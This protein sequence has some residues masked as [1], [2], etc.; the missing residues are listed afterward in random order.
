[1]VQ[2][3]NRINVALDFSISINKAEKIF[4]HADIMWS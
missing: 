2:A 4:K 1:M 3:I